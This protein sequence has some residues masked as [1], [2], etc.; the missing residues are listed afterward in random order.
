MP[1]V[2]IAQFESCHKE[3]FGDMIIS[4]Q[5]PTEG[6]LPTEAVLSVPYVVTIKRRHHMTKMRQTSSKRSEKER[7]KTLLN[8]LLAEINSN[9]QISTT[10]YNST[11]GRSHRSLW[12]DV[13]DLE[14]KD[15]EDLRTTVTSFRC[16]VERIGNVLL[17]LLKRRDDLLCQQDA[18]CDVITRRLLEIQCK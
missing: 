5:T 15:L 3:M 14:S 4:C 17:R 13:G 12:Q 10:D 2:R 7:A 9:V 8:E 11:S 18:F 1:D 16:Y 6:S